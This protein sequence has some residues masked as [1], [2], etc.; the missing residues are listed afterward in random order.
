MSGVAAVARGLYDWWHVLWEH[1]DQPEAADK[2][3]RYAQAFG[4]H[5]PPQVEMQ[6]EPLSSSQLLHASHKA[7]RIAGGKDG[8]NAILLR[9]LPNAAL[10][11]LADL[12]NLVEDVGVWP[13][14]MYHWRIVFIS[15]EG[16][17]AIPRP[18][19]GRPIAIAQLLYRM[20]A[21]VRA[22]QCSKGVSSTFDSRQAGGK[23]LQGAETL[24]FDVVAAEDVHD[25]PFMGSYDFL[26]AFDSVDPE[27][28]VHCLRNVGLPVQYARLLLDMWRKQVRW[29]SFG[30]A[31][32]PLP[33]RD[34]R[35]MPQGDPWAMWAMAAIL[36]PVLRKLKA[37]TSGV[38]TFA[39]ADDR[40]MR[41]KSFDGL[42]HALQ[43]WEEFAR[44]G[45]RNNPGKDQQVC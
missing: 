13:D 18:P 12:L 37:T 19:E 20:W 45:I 41:A 14:E 21:S 6:V 10:Q 24:L 35:A 8:W 2:D 30:G 11:Q 42:H 22:E 3:R 7:M 27:L 26:K 4:S 28:A 16:T 38:R 44:T 5:L 1:T 9:C 32:H 29:I 39:F 31:V 40:T 36:I 25:M 33:V 43:Q 34:V 15:K 17:A 23:G